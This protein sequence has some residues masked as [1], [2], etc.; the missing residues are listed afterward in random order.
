MQA[1][2]LSGETQN[3]FIS[4]CADEVL[5]FILAE[6]EK[7][8]YFSVIVDATPDSAHIEQTVFVL[9]YLICINEEG[10]EKYKPV[11]RFLAFVDCNQKTGE[12]IRNLILPTLEDKRIDI[13]GV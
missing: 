12:A 9:R 4:C 7:A 10:A 2:Y 1:H 5:P 11:E 8:K 6:R 13:Q 3:Y